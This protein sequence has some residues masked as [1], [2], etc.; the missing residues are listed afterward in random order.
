MFYDSQAQ[1]L[2]EQT[3]QPSITVCS[4]I[5]DTW[6]CVHVCVILFIFLN[7]FG[8]QIIIIIITIAII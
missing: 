8:N 7:Y 2:V 4:P 3:N 1:T 5:S 6:Y